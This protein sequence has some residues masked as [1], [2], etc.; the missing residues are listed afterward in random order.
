MKYMDHQQIQIRAEKSEDKGEIYEVNKLAFGKDNEAKL[1]DL[2]RAREDFI[3]ELS[4]VAIANEKIVGYVLL[5]KIAI[6]SEDQKRFDSLAL[7]PVSVVPDSQKQGVGKLLITNVLEKAKNLG[8]ESVIVLGHKEYY[9]KFGFGLAGDWGIKA[10]FDVPADHFM[11]IELK[12]GSLDGKSG[13]VEYPPEL[14]SV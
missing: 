2:L 14:L 13:I 12:K 11:A 6:V 3:P 8:Y 9:P 7:A 4:L 10:P 1:V 5:S